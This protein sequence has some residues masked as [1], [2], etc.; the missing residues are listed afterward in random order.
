MMKNRTCNA[1]GT[2]PKSNRKTKETEGNSIF[3]IQTPEKDHSIFNIS[4][5]RSE[6]QYNQ[7]REL[8]FIMY[9]LRPKKCV[10]TLHDWIQNKTNN[11][12]FII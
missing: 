4:S 5:W 3:L 8:F 10:I 11:I 1:V 7:Q 12:F 9:V 2:V 6:I